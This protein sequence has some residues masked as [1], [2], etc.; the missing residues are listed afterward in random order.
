MTAEVPDRTPDTVT[1]LQVSFERSR[2]PVGATP[3]HIQYVMKKQT[4]VGLLEASRTVEIAAF[5]EAGPEVMDGRMFTVLS[6]ALNE[7][8]MNR[9]LEAGANTN[10]GTA[11]A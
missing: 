10:F 5:R 1:L 7:E 4:P 11:V 3:T 2:V 9:L 6:A 8:E